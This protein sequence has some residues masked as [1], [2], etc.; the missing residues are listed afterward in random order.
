MFGKFFYG[1][2]SLR[3]AFWKFSVLGLT[4]LGF[5]AVIFK[6]ILMQTVNYEQN[7]LRVATNA[8]SFVK[9]SSTSMAIFAVY[10]ASFIALIIYSII[11]IGGMWNTYKEYDK[12]K[13]L[14]AI[15][16]LL[17]WVMIFFAVKYAI[18]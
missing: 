18:Y 5:L 9:D 8:L 17:V 3:E 6:R 10:I 11:C 4:A 15:C 2:L 13:T 12:S 16:M 14:A 7:F 1:Q